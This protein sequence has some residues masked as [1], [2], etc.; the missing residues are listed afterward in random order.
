[1]DLKSEN[2]KNDSGNKKHLNSAKWSILILSSLLLMG[3]YFAFD[4]PFAILEELKAK[5]LQNNFSEEEFQFYFDL[6]YTVYVFPNIFLP[7]FNGIL[8][9][10]VN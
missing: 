9:E 4:V 5:F 10:K 8:T 7:F 6:L 3:D 2:K 1:M